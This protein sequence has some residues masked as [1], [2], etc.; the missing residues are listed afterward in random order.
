MVYMID[1]G[2]R[3]E[4]AHSD[5]N[6][7]FAPV[8][9]NN[10]DYELHATFVAGILA[11]K[12]QTGRVRGINPNAVVMTVNRGDF[13]DGVPF[14]FDW[15]LT[16][17]EVN[18]IYGVVNF[19]SV[20]D[21]DNAA[22]RDKMTQYIRRVS[23][24][25][26]VVQSA[27]N[28]Y[29]DAC[30]HAYPNPNGYDGILVVGGIDQ[31]MRPVEPGPQGQ[32]GFDNEGTPFLSQ[33]GSNYGPC[34]EVWAPSKNI[35][36]TSWQA[37]DPPPYIALSRGSGT[38]FAAPHVAGLAARYWGQTPVE[39]ERFIRQKVYGTGFSDHMSNPVTVPSWT[40]PLS[41]QL[42]YRLTPAATYASSGTNMDAVNDGLYLSTRVWNAGHGAPAWIEFD[43]GATK[44]ITSVRLTPEQ[45]PEGYVLHYIYAGDY[46]NPPFAVA[47]IN[48]Y[49]RTLE[50]LSRSVGACGRYLRVETTQ[51]PSWVAWRE[52][53]ILGY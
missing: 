18:G 16:H 37:S 28:L 47:G 35:L 48:D 24:R 45:T 46:P 23:N 39:K 1:G 33:P 50:P 13:D 11:A 38:S 51:S 29:H 42:P 4:H 20:V 2:I 26:L 52:I 19:S 44:C 34:V 43:L 8:N 27:G 53:E 10:Y 30:A 31:A 15:V 25:A 36:S 32:P 6:L 41:G 49:G 40:W 5:L 7:Q 22:W 3:S 21:T 14:A 9:P 12:M 17:A